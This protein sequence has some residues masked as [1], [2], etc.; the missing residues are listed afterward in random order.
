VQGWAGGL[1]TFAVSLGGNPINSAVMNH[2]HIV[3]EDNRFGAFA[4]VST[5]FQNY[6]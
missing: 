3:L 4:P 5:S 6:P 2:V 1:A